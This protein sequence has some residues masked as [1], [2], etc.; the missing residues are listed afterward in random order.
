MQDRKDRGECV[1]SFDYGRA[2]TENIAEEGQ[3]GTALYAADSETKTVLCAPVVA[4]GSAS[5][6]E[7]IEELLRFSMTVVNANSVV[8]QAEG[9]QSS[10]WNEYGDPYNTAR[11]EECPKSSKAGKHSFAEEKANIKIT[12]QHHIYPWSFRHA[13]WLITWL[14]V[15]N[16]GSTSFE[17]MRDRQYNGKIVLFGETVLFKDTMRAKWKGEPTI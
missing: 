1:V 2:F 12:G 6:S 4:K 8:F 9:C 11:R 16:D 15:I 17:V 7:V 10:A 13:A 14:R 3:M 5:L